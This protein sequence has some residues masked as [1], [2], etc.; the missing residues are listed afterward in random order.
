MSNFHSGLFKYFLPNLH[1]IIII[2]FEIKH[3]PALPLAI[4]H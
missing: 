2:T 1:K 3:L 4:V